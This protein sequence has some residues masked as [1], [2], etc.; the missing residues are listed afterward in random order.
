MR[1]D[2]SNKADQKSQTR[3]SEVPSEPEEYDESTTRKPCQ[4]P[5][6]KTD[7]RASFPRYRVLVA[8][9]NMVNCHIASRLLQ[10]LDCLVDVA[11][12]GREAVSMHLRQAYDMVLMDCQM[13]ELDGF[14]ATAQI[15]A[16]EAG[17]RRTPVIAWTTNMRQ[18]ERDRCAAAG[19]DD[20]V[21][22]P[23]G[24]HSLQQV[25]SLWLRPV[26][27]SQPVTGGVPRDDQLETMQEL[28]RANFDELAALYQHDTPGRIDA[29]RAA[30]SAADLAKMTRIAHVLSGSCASIGATRLAGMFRDLELRCRDGRCDDWHYRVSV[31]D[32]EYARIRAKLQPLT[33]AKIV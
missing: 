18:E 20:L 26:E 33:V 11:T 24:L 10:K 16:A 6:M 22:K 19:M 29:F 21:Q 4:R 9:D 27:T 3:S 15:R 12:S 13:P 1:Y 2:R 32:T 17:S 8:D 25:L 31:I 7:A 14:Q 5:S 28:F 30:A 23:I